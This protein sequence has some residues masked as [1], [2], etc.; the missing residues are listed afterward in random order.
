MALGAAIKREFAGDVR[1]ILLLDVTP[2]SF[3]IE[4]LGSVFTKMVE[5]NT[6]I[7]VS[8][9]QIFLNSRGQSATSVEVHVLQ[10]EREM[11]RD[12]KTLGRFILDGIP[13]APPAFLKWK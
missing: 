2:L 12:N 9:S 4:T 7:P 1:D 11:A 8:K 5:K 10:G 13:P 3:G 6:T